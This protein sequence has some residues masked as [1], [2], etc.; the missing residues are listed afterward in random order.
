M[1]E[2]EL[3]EDELDSELVEDEL[4]VR[5]VLELAT[6]LCLCSLRWAGNA[7]AFSVCELGWWHS[8]CC[9]G[10]CS[11]RWTGKREQCNAHGEGAVSHASLRWCL[12]SLRWT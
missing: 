5:E 8:L 11:M 2:A 3:V 6:K 9:A 10:L 4:D 7:C 1:L 12:C